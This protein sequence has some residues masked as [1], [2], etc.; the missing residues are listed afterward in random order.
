M[1]KF[2]R[3]ATFLFLGF[4]FFPRKPAFRLARQPALPFSFQV[5]SEKEA[6]DQRRTGTFTANSPT[7][8]SAAIIDGIIE[9]TETSCCVYLKL[10]EA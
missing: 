1:F 10:W 6:R 8:H 3:N 9:V 4:V 7:L 2:L 5:T